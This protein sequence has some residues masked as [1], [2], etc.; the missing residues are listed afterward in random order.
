M[1]VVMVVE[2]EERG[3][4]APPPQIRP[5]GEEQGYRSLPAGKCPVEGAAL[6]LGRMLVRGALGVGMEGKRG[7]ERPRDKMRR[8]RRGRRR[9][10]RRETR[11]G[12]AANASA[13][14]VAA[15]P[16][17]AARSVPR[18]P[19]GHPTTRRC[20]RTPLAPPALQLQ[21]HLQRELQRLLEE[22]GRW[23]RRVGG[24]RRRRIWGGYA[25]RAGAPG[26]LAMSGK[27]LGSP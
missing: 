8:R 13:S 5:P 16:P 21:Q 19:L 1:V 12:S 14:S 25:E 26:V 2:E 20:P 23:R 6:A 27:I 10:R 18:Q 15:P 3:R 17:E 24:A 22:W 4:C 9:R 7:G 11:E